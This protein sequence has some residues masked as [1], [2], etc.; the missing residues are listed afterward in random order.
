MAEHPDGMAD[1]TR[2]S[3][4]DRDLVEHL[5]DGVAILE[6]GA[7]IGWANGRLAE[8]CGGEPCGRDFFAALGM[9]P[10]DS[11]VTA[12]TVDRGP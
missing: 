8:W 10:A 12:W 6:N 4:P 1:A 5:P 9:A 3:S 7:T 2:A 11:G